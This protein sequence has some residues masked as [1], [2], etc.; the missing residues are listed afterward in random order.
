[1]TSAM[2]SA[3]KGIYTIYMNCTYNKCSVL[4]CVSDVQRYGLLLTTKR[5]L[6]IEGIDNYKI[7]GSDT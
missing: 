6:N 4:L 3:M 5:F 7:Q 2:A 1:M